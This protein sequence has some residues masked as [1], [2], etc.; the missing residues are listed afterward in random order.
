MSPMI[1][2][3]GSCSGVSVVDVD[4]GCNR[5]DVMLIGCNMLS[6][7]PGCHVSLLADHSC[8]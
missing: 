5:E 3:E 4:H 7:S 8:Q 6:M 2:A 1:R